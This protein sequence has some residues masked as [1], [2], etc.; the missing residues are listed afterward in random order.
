M[1]AILNRGYY[2]YPYSIPVQIPVRV[3]GT[4]DALSL[5]GPAQSPGGSALF[6]LLTNAVHPAARSGLTEAGAA[7]SP[8]EACMRF[9]RR[10]SR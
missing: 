2:H 7:V 3:Q 8:W 4:T 10:P 6:A 1:G 9:S 5:V